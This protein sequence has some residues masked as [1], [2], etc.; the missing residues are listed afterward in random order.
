EQGDNP[1]I[2]DSYVCYELVER[3]KAPLPRVLEEEK[4]LDELEEDDDEMEDAAKSEAEESESSKESTLEE[5]E[6]EESIEGLKIYAYINSI[7]GEVS[8]AVSVKRGKRIPRSE[9]PN[10]GM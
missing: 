4:G 7:T 2:G 6:Q 5:I 9:N 3:Q 1:V 10:N 8:D